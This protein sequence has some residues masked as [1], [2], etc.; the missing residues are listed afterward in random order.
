MKTDESQK[1][2]TRKRNQ[3]SVREMATE[4]EFGKTEAKKKVWKKK[5]RVEIDKR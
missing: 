3:Q 5:F 4:K 2:E 1:S